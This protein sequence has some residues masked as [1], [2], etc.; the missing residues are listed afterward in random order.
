MFPTAAP[1]GTSSLPEDAQFW[2]PKPEDIDE[3]GFGFFRD[4][5]LIRNVP[6]AEANDV[7]EEER[8]IAEAIAGLAQDAERFDH[9]AG[10]AEFGRI[11]DPEWALTEPELKVLADH[12]SDLPANLGGLEIG[13]AGL[14]HA[15]A[16]VRILP[17]ASCRSHPAKSWSD[18]P[19]VLFA[20]TE[21]RARALEPLV[22]STG[23]TF[24]IDENRR[25]LLVVRGR[26]IEYL[27]DLADAVMANRSSF[28]KPRSRGRARKTPP[29]RA[30]QDPLF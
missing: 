6:V 22:E 1:A 2:M 28:V 12:V 11:D 13:V 9:L 17:A 18:A 23:C 21:F 3:E 29:R 15:L 5:W 16:T 27:M 19:V 30:V 24:A 25:N 10:V 4:T 20:A 8:Q 26:S 14:T 7:I